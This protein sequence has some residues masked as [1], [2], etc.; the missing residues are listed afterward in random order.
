MKHYN[1]QRDR[2]ARLERDYLAD[3]TPTPA[4]EQYDYW[5]EAE[6]A[7]YAM[8]TREFAFFLVT[9]GAIVAA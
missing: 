5:N 4:T 7:D 8:S 3:T 2:Q 6:S 9:G 1:P